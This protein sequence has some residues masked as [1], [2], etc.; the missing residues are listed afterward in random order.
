MRN[1]LPLLCT[2]FFFGIA[3]AQEPSNSELYKTLKVKDSLIFDVGFNTC[4][5][6][7]FENLLAEDLEFYHDKAGITNTK[8]AFVSSFKNGICG[9]ANFKSRRELLPETLEVF[10]LFNNGI[11]YGAVQKGVHRFFE[12]MDGKPET[13][14]STAMFTHL[15]LKE[16]TGWKIK[17]VL[18]YNHQMI[19]KSNNEL[20]EIQLSKTI[21]QGYVGQYT[22]PR[23]G[24]IDVSYNG[25]ALTLKADKM[26]LNIVPSSETAFFDKS[27]AL[28]FEFVNDA[29]GNA[30]KFIVFENGKKVE[31]AIKE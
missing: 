8:A 13:K 15:W 30:L 26:V 12:S 18:S 4:N 6:S 19:P 27:N 16:E 11:L 14:G 3:N 7:A 20:N 17:R 28:T 1:Y 23:A 29:E 10:P 5:L 25:T 31:E 2:F 22:S 9:N 24:T 21:L